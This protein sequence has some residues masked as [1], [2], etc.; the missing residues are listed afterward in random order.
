MPKKPQS[1]SKTTSTQPKKVEEKKV[2]EKKV[3]QPKVEEKKVEQKVE[4]KK[5]DNKK[6]EPKKKD[7][8]KTEKK[9]EPKKEPVAQ[10]KF[11]VN[12]ERLEKLKKMEKDVIIGGK[13]SVR[14]KKKEI[15]HN[16]Q[17]DEQKLQTVL[18]K[19]N[20]RPFDLDEATFFME[21]ST[22]LQFSKPKG[23]LL[24]QGNTFVVSGKYEKKSV[25][26]YLPTLLSQMGG[27]GALQ[28]LKGFPDTKQD[29]DIPELESFEKKEEA[30]ETTETK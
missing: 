2:E 9:T 10:H 12:K 24:M 14:R 21:D 4:E 7:A 8:P 20:F 23:N 18:K 5:V 16:S 3:E 17:A 26:E 13:G 30:K 28:G 11:E 6:T 15:R 1:K 19:N 25:Q 22:V 29:D 27:M